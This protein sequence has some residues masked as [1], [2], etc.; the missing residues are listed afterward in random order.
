MSPLPAAGT[1]S[2]D[3]AGVKGFGFVT[4]SCCHYLLAE[5][6]R[7][8]RVVLCSGQALAEAGPI[9]GH[10]TLWRA[11]DLVAGILA[12]AASE[13]AQ[14]LVHVLPRAAHSV[15]SVTGGRLH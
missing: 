13:L 4:R 5:P 15:L 11:D 14:Y 9:K 1:S 7:G 6:R 12:A 2:G 3:S 8:V 10:S